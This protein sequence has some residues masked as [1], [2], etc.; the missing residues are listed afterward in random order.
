MTNW[1][2][3]HAINYAINQP[4]S[5]LIKRI[6]TTSSTFPACVLCPTN[7]TTC[8]LRIS[9]QLHVKKK[10]SSFILGNLLLDVLKDESL[11]ADSLGAN[12]LTRWHGSSSHAIRSVFRHEGEM[13]KFGYCWKGRWWWIVSTVVLGRTFHPRFRSSWQFPFSIACTLKTSVV[14]FHSMT[15]LRFFDI[16]CFHSERPLWA[17]YFRCVER[18]CDH[19]RGLIILLRHTDKK[20]AYF[21]D[22]E[23]ILFE[24]CYLH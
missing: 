19:S 11:P 16:R 6:P 8:S 18:K 24:V 12:W 7:R 15:W 4:N 17:F 1:S 2:I 20:R 5:L 22:R 14:Y 10:S 21:I 13:L 23:I 9:F 3:C